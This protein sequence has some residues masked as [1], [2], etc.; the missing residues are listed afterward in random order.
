MFAKL[1]AQFRHGHVMGI[2][3]E[4][5]NHVGLRDMGPQ[6][7]FACH[8][9]R[10]GGTP[11]M[12]FDEIHR[13][14]SGSGRH[15]DQATGLFKKVSDEGAGH[16]TRTEDKYA[17]IHFLRTSRASQ[18]TM[19]SCLDAVKTLSDSVPAAIFLHHDHHGRVSGRGIFAA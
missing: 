16:E 1:D 10:H 14:V 3:D 13:L 19:N 12:P 6:V 5:D 7:L 18:A 17:I 11:G 9:D 2:G 8:V 4:A 15:G